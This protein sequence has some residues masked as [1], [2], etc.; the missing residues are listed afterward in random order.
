MIRNNAVQKHCRVEICTQWLLRALNVNKLPT[1]MA[2]VPPGRSILKASAMMALLAC[3][4]SSC[5]TKQMDTRSAELAGKPVCSAAAC[6]NLQE[7][8][9]HYGAGTA[10]VVTPWHH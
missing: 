6:W 7:A 3:S 2:K 5:I 1:M 8:L 9:R 4:G 10:G